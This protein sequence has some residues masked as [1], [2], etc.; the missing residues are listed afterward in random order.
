MTRALISELPA[1]AS[2]TLFVW[3]VVKVAH[4]I[5]GGA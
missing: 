1:L 5:T 4:M 3:A 2:I